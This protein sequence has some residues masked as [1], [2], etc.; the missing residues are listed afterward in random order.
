M[1][2]LTDKGAEKVQEFLT[3][4]GNPQVTGLRVGVRGGGCSGFQY[5]LAFDEQR[6]GDTVVTERGIKLLVDNASVPYVQGSTTTTSSSRAPASRSTRTSSPPA[7]AS[8]ALRRRRGLRPSGCKPAQR[9]RRSR[10]CQPPLRPTPAW[11]SLARLGVVLALIAIA[12]GAFSAARAACQRWRPSSSRRRAAS[13]SPRRGERQPLG[14]GGPAAF[15]PWRDR[16]AALAPTSSGSTWSGPSCSPRRAHR[17]T[18][19][20]RSAACAT[21]PRALPRPARAL[22]LRQQRASGRFIGYVVFR[23]PAV[24]RDAAPRADA[25]AGRRR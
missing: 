5:L 6:D 1:L 25:G 18:G 7:G 22:R 21:C 13:P 15:A 24:G 2:T 20:P 14:T 4:Q 3:G 23:R 17:P 16:P 10:A 9:P 19:T 8:S 11:F 12:I